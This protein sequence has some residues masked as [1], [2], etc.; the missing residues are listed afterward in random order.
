MW[1]TRSVDGRLVNPQADRCA[2]VNGLKVLW[3][4]VCNNGNGLQKWLMARDG[5]IRNPELSMCLDVH[6]KK[7]DNGTYVLV[8]ACDGQPSQQWDLRDDGTIRH[9]QS[10]K[11]VDI[12][13]ANSADGTL[14]QLW[15]CIAGTP[16]NQKWRLE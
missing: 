15:N 6:Q 11:C 8:A 14:L 7:L 9:P 10:G 5:T 16:W 4:Q 2:E 1:T 13:G 3:I 12:T